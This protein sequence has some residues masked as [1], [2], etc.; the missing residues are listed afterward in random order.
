MTGQSA[1]VIGMVA[2][3]HVHVGVGQSSG[4]LD[5]PVARESATAWPFIPGSGLK[6][7]MRVWAEEHLDRASTARLFGAELKDSGTDDGSATQAGSLMWSD[8]RLLLFPVRSMAGA[9]RL[10]TSAQMINRFRRDKRRIGLSTP[11]PNIEN[12]ANG[13]YWGAKEEHAWLGL[14]EREF[15]HAGDLPAGLVDEV[16]AVVGDALSAEHL[17][18]R[19]VILSDD[20]MGW[21]ARF[22]LPIMSRNKLDENKAVAHGML[23]DEEALPPDTVMYALVAERTLLKP[24]ARG[25]VAQVVASMTDGGS[26]VQLGGN[27]TI[28]QG[29]FS[30]KPLLGS[31]AT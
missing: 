18:R 2:E 16:A 31:E 28:G 15:Q 5:L 9:Y 25:G 12:V 30:L 26:Y 17:A 3:T 7:G 22:A 8:A 1:M 6:G 27:E 14:E 19:I 10:V 29:W 13:S 20:D 21:F 11:A 24:E 23:W 4:A